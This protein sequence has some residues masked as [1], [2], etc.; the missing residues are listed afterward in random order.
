MTGEGEL[1]GTGAAARCQNAIDVAILIVQES[2]IFAIGT[3]RRRGWLTSDRT[4]EALTSGAQV[5]RANVTNTVDFVDLS[6]TIVG[7]IGT[8][9]DDIAI[10]RPSGIFNYRTARNLYRRQWGIRSIQC[11]CENLTPW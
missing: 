3:A 8:H 6:F 4:I 10:R 5:N 9:V 2:D 7:G 11:D 1:L